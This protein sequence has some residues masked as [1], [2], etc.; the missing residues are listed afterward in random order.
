MERPSR[1]Q[2][3]RFEIDCTRLP[4]RPEGLE[5]EPTGR[6]VCAFLKGILFEV[7]E[8]RSA[9]ECDWTNIRRL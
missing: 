6:G 9:L 7:A 2:Q 1:H 4:Q 8:T 3:V 5:R